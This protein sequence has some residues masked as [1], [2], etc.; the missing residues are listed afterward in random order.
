MIVL[1]VVGMAN[2]EH[3][4]APS[5][6]LVVVPTNWSAASPPIR[7]AGIALEEAREAFGKDALSARGFRTDPFAPCEFEDQPLS[8]TGDIGDRARVATM[9]ARPRPPA[10]RTRSDLC[11]GMQRH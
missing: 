4:R 8:T 11:G 5:A 7:H 9:D 6:P 1:P 3:R 10:A 2:C